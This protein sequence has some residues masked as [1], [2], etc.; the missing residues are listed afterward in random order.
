MD[1][2]DLAHGMGLETAK[3]M[4]HRM[5]QQRGMPY[6]PGCVGEVE[7]RMSDGRLIARCP[8]CAGAE[9]VSRTDPEFFCLSCGMALNDCHPMTALLPEEV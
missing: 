2:E 6:R 8:Y 3:R 5:A 7:A 4:R 1:A 9:A